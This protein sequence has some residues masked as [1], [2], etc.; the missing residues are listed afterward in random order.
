[1]SSQTDQEL[2]QAFIVGRPR[3]AQGPDEQ[4]AELVE[5]LRKQFA[6]QLA[7]RW[8]SLLRRRDD[9][10]GSAF[11]TLVRW[12]HSGL[13][14]AT[15][16]LPQLAERL[17]HEVARAEIRTSERIKAGTEE[18]ALQEPTLPITPERSSSGRELLSRIAGLVALLPPGQARALHALAAHERGDGPPVAEVLQC[19]PATARRQIER[20]RL[21]LA[22]LAVQQGLGE[23]LTE[24][25]VELT[26]GIL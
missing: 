13:L 22:A 23:S 5:R 8:P 1:M 20:A 10:E 12:R 6:R 9:L 24:A 11:V 16:S 21:A 14:V 25:G 3:D 19:D 2:L 15:E 4:R 7:R 18:L 26:G 17:A